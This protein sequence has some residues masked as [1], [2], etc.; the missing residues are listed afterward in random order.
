MALLMSPV[1]LD[2]TGPLLAAVLYA[3]ATFMLLRFTTHP[4]SAARGLALGITAAAMI[5]HTVLEYH[6]WIHQPLA[7]IDISTTLSLCALVVV[8]IWVATLFRRNAV[9]E[10]GLIVLPLAA[11]ATLVDALMPGPTLAP[12][13]A[14]GAAAT[15]TVVHVV[16]SVLAFGILGLAG[17]YA[18]LVLAVD[19]SLKRHELNRR[20]QNLPPLDLLESFLFKLIAAGLAILTVSLASGLIFVDDLMAQ[21]LAHK[22]ILSSL[23]WVVFGALLLGRWR[24]GWRGSLAVRLTLAGIGLLLLSYFGSKL[25]LE[26]IL[27]RS[28][29]S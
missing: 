25:V 22:T 23:A 15:G 16:S 10:P 1:F 20:I 9:L 17:V 11:I 24:K 29:Y 5:L 2:T 18:I 4:S 6:D 19:H 27:G 12:H 21:H 13:P 7:G 28:W 14:L 8:A 3:A 26:V